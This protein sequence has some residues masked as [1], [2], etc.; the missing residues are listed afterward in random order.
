MDRIVRI[1]FDAENKLED[2]EV[3]QFRVDEIAEFVRHYC[4]SVA[5]LHTYVEY[6]EQSVKM[7]T[8]HAKFADAILKGGKL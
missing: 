3:I 5:T 8:E 4:R 6:H 1:V 2:H 7:H